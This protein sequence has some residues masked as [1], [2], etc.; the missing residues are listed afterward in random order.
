MYPV[1]L[2]ANAPSA[3]TRISLFAQSGIGMASLKEEVLAKL[4]AIAAPDG[5]P[6]PATGKLSEIVAGDGKVFFSI[7]VDAA[8]IG[9]AR[10]T[11]EAVS[12]RCCSSAA[13][14]S[15][16]ATPGK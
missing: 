2:T 3:A 16:R 12:S 9:G 14:P 1:R 13:A 10:K 11:L 6:L 7:T 8:Q 4:A 5:R 15:R